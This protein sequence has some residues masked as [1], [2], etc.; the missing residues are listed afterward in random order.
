MCALLEEKP[1]LLAKMLATIRTWMSEK[2]KEG[3]LLSGFGDAPKREEVDAFEVGEVA[4]IVPVVD[5]DKVQKKSFKKGKKE[6]KINVVV[7]TTAEEP[8]TLPLTET[9]LPTII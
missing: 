6:K 3:V 2:K 8:K 7:S 4:S 9:N 5:S 1:E